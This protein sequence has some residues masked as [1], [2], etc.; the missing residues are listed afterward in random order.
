MGAE[1][2]DSKSLSSVNDL[3]GEGLTAVLTETKAATKQELDNQIKEM[4]QFLNLLKHIHRFIL[5]IRKVN[6]PSIG[7][8]VPEFFHQ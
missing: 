6:T 2:L 4:K 3:T 1:L 5:L 7:A 8:F